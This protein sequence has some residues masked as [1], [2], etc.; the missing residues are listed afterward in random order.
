MSHKENLQNES[1]CTKRNS[2]SVKNQPDN[3][4]KIRLPFY[5]GKNP[6]LLRHHYYTKDLPRNEY[7]ENHL[8]YTRCVY[9]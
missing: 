3:P 4:R 2:L 9:D 1:Y 7:L 6:S 8:Q 5:P